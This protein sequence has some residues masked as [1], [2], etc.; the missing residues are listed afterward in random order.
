MT[1]SPSIDPS[2]VQLAKKVV[3]HGLAQGG[4]DDFRPIEATALR[5]VLAAL[6]A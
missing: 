6:K 2:L 3:A 1:S 4:A 5:A